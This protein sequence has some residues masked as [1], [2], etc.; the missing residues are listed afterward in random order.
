MRE[1]ELFLPVPEAY[2][3][4]SSFYDSYANPMV[5]MAAEIVRRTLAGARGRSVFEFGCGT[6]RNLAALESMGAKECAGCDLSQ[7]MLQVARTRVPRAEL[8]CHDLNDPLPI[9]DAAFDVALL[10]L[11]LEHV[12]D[13]RRPLREAARI[14][15]TQ[16]RICVIE[17]HPF[18]SLTGARANFDHDGIEVSMPTYAH[19]FADYLNA[20]R[21]LGLAVDSCREWKP[22]DVGNPPQLQGLKRGPDFPLTLEFSLRRPD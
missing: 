17:I 22:V 11:T 5:F 1:K 4:W 21:E 2:D 8:F 14:T 15:K 20:F 7:G 3:R 16:G 12:S 9:R 18:Y 19:Q 10:C 13:L 6:G